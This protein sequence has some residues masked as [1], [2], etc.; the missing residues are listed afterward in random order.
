MRMTSMQYSI[1]T[2]HINTI[3]NGYGIKAMTQHRN[4]VKFAQDQFISFIWSI[5]W[6]INAGDRKLIGEELNDSH[7]ETALKIALKDYK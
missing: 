1:L 5:Y 6:M 7:I 3:E 4:G 2:E